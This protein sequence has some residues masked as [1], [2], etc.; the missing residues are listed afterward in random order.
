[1]GFRVL[2]QF[3]LGDR[4]V[5][6]GVEI[7]PDGESGQRQQHAKA[8]YPRHHFH[9]LFPPRGRQLPERTFEW[10]SE[11]APVKPSVDFLW[12]LRQRTCITSLYDGTSVSPF[13]S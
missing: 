3:I 9:D 7:L 5:G 2:D 10:H 12:Q 8:G 13:A 11:Q 1:V 4:G 6:R